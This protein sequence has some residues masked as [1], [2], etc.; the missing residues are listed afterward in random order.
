M[1]A[2]RRRVAFLGLEGDTLRLEVREPSRFLVK[3]LQAKGFQAEAEGEFTLRVS[4]SNWETFWAQA[5]PLFD[6]GC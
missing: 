1:E 3:A 4:A 6:C 2:A 5:G